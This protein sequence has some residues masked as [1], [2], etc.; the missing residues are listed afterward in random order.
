MYVI[1]KQLENLR[2]WAVPGKVVVIYGP[3]RTGKTTLLT[4]F[5]K[6]EAEPYTLATGEDITVQ[7]YLASQSVEK[8]KAFV[9]AVRLLVV[10]E[11]Q[12]IP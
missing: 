9:G 2:R 3:R 6:A 7:S 11:A 1:Q 4:E 12:K 5:L 8:L 10:D